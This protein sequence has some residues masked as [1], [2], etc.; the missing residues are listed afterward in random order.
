[1]SVSTFRFDFISIWIKLFFFKQP[2][3]Y[4]MSHRNESI[5]WKI[6]MNHSGKLI[7]QIKKIS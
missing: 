4:T 7:S 2:E 1:M 6:K 3:K 5:K